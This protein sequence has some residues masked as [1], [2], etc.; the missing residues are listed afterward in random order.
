[1]ESKAKAKA[2][3]RTKERVACRAWRQLEPYFVLE[4][5]SVD[6]PFG[7]ISHHLSIHSDPALAH[8]HQPTLSHHH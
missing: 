2:P 6:F 5:G 1:M 3:L 4:L 8:Q 7:Q